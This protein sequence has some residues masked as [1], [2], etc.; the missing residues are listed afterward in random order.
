VEFQNS[1]RPPSKIVKKKLKIAPQGV[2]VRF[3]FFTQIFVYII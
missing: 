2:G 1:K 3:L